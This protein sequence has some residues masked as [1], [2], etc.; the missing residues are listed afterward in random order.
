M[1]TAKETADKSG[2]AADWYAYTIAV[3]DYETA[4]KE[5]GKA[6]PKV[7]Q[8]LKEA[9]DE[10]AGATEAA[11]AQKEYDRDMT[12]FARGVIAKNKLLASERALQNAKDR[13]R[14]QEIRV[15]LQL[16]EYEYNLI[17]F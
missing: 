7:Y 12:L 5:A 14:Q 2:S 3:K 8:A 11:D 9:Y 17:K 4:N 13:Y 10:M 16:M 15:W 1:K 6:F